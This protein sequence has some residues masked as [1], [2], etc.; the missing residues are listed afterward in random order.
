M[1]GDG[2][3]LTRNLLENMRGYLRDSW[4]DTGFWP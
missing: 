1:A 4:A 2:K 3:I